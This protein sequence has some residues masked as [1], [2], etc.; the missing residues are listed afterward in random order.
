[1]K[2]HVEIA[3]AT[4]DGNRPHIRIFQ[5]MKMEGSTLFFATSSDKEV[6]YYILSASK[7]INN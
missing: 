7:A 4:S 2:N 5:I 1:M 6:Y 3:F